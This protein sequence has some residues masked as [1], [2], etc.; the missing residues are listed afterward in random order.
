ME[1]LK[2]IDNYQP[3]GEVEF[4]RVVYDRVNDL[5][6]LNEKGNYILAIFNVNENHSTIPILGS[7]WGRYFDITQIDSIEIEGNKIEPTSSY[8]FTTYG[9]VQVKYHMN[10]NFTNTEYMFSGTE[11]KIV[12]L[13]QCDL[14]NVTSMSGMFYFEMT[15]NEPENNSIETFTIGEQQLPNLTDISSMFDG[16]R[17]LSNIPYDLLKCVTSIDNSAFSYCDSLT[18]VIIPNNITSIGSRAFSSCENLTSIEIPSSVTSIGGSAFYD[19][20]RLT[21]IT[22]LAITAP[23]INYST[24]RDI[25][26]N[27]ILK[28]PQG[29]DYSSWLDELGDGWTIEY[30]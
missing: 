4:I 9:D 27:G 8:T 25:A 11:A 15:E 20:S 28:V 19:C 13:S 22:C 2:L 3:N 24:F 10:D 5:V 23:S 14:S 26:S 21:S 17:V 16:C 7:V 12:D 30:V 1:S 29:S 6:W 18:N